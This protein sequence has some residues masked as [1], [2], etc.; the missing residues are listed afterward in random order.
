MGFKPDPKGVRK[1][2]KSVK[3]RLKQ[4]LEAKPKAKRRFRGWKA[5]VVAQ[6]EEF[7]VDVPIRYQKITSR[8]IDEAMNII[9]KSKSLGVEVNRKLLGEYH[10]GYWLQDREAVNK[11]VE[12]MIQELREKGEW[13]KTTEE[14][15]NEMVIKASEVP[16]ED[17]GYF[18]VIDGEE[19]EVQQFEKTK[20]FEITNFVDKG[21]LWNFLLENFYELWS[22]KNGLWLLADYLQQHNKLAVCSHIVLRKSFKEYYGLIFPVVRGD[23]YT[24]VMALTR[25]NL[26][27]QHLRPA[28]P[29][30]EKPARP[31]TV[32]KSVLKVDL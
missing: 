20:D 16:S 27:Y 17:V 11:R 7:S 30:A 2:G 9:T 31:K 3:S 1:L 26:E 22:E 21:K 25:M 15:F 23:Q 5:T 12:D 29:I 24:F 6:T 8:A 18:Q 28:K 4:R 19:R 10:Y 32:P 14:Q 13:E